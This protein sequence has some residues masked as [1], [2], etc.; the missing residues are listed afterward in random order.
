MSY[1]YDETDE[2]YDDS[3]EASIERALDAL[4]SRRY[5]VAMAHFALAVE[6]HKE[7]EVRPR[8][9]A[10]EPEEDSQCRKEDLPNLLTDEWKTKAE[11]WNA[12]DVFDCPKASFYRWWKELKEEG[13]PDIEWRG[14]RARRK[15]KEVAPDSSFT[16]EPDTRTK[17]E[18]E[19]TLAKSRRQREELDRLMLER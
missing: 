8:H 2:E 12:A 17:E 18:I 5:G 19:A 9:R 14:E 4:K 1:D 6:L 11:W 16:V 13:H 15:Q 7:I 3:H 10:P